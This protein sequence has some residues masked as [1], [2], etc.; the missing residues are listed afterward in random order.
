M[1]E[2]EKVE[3]L[4]ERLFFTSPFPSFALLHS[5]LSPRLLLVLRDDLSTRERDVDDDENEMAIG[6][7]S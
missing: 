6:F 5:T 2:E 3:R 4:G 1:N 7:F